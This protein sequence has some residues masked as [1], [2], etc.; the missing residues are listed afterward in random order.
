MPVGKKRKKRVHPSSYLPPTFL[1]RQESCLQIKK[2]VVRLGLMRR[3]LTTAQSCDRGVLVLQ[4]PL[5]RADSIR[6]VCMSQACVYALYVY[7]HVYT[8]SILTKSKC[9]ERTCPPRCVGEWSPLKL[10]HRLLLCLLNSGGYTL[11]IVLLCLLNSGPSALPPVHPSTPPTP[12][13]STHPT[14]KSNT[15]N[16]HK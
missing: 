8:I 4:G 3:R 14:S 9:A 1:L 7:T 5:R 10:N 11:Y 16:E 13:L 6:Y 12:I 2:E 15:S